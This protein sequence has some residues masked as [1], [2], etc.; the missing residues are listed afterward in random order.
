MQGL[1]YLDEERKELMGRVDNALRFVSIW[2]FSFFFATPPRALLR[3]LSSISSSTRT[4]DRETKLEAIWFRLGCFYYV[5]YWLLETC[6]IS[7]QFFYWIEDISCWR[8]S[9][10]RT[11]SMTT[12][13]MT[14][15]KF[16]SIRR[17]FVFRWNTSGGICWFLSIFRIL[18]ISS[19]SN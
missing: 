10:L 12:S 7:C 9:F 2:L 16:N 13:F 8:C 11:H 5:S 3:Q 18:S 14:E 1:S 19:F 6:L 15:E 17:I 4:E